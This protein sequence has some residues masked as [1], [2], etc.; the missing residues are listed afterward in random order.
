[1]GAWAFVEAACGGSRSAATTSATSP[2][3]SPAARPPARKTI[4]DQ[5]LADLMDETFS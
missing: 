4:H 2:A 1:M 3:S 5:E